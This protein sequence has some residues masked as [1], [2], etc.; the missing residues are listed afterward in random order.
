LV[1][2]V[3]ITQTEINAELRMCPDPMTFDT[4]GFHVWIVGRSV[5]K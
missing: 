2:R 4:N 5:E 1:C 3:N